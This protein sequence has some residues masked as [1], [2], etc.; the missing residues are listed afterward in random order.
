MLC[1]M[2]FFIYAKTAKL[3]FN[4]YDYLSPTRLW[5]IS[6]FDQIK[7]IDIFMLNNLFGFG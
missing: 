6:I 5:C 3:L 7:F 2:L 4:Y 1:A